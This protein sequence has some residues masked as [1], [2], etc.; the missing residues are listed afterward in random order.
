MSRQR[1]SN[2]RAATGGAVTEV[3][4]QVFKLNGR[5]L[6]AGDQLTSDIG[7]T[8]ARWQVLGAVALAGTPQPVANLAR[9]MG[10]TR[11]AV[12]RTVNDLASRGLVT[13]DVNPHHRRA[14]LVVLTEEGR[15][16]YR[17]AARRQV[18]W[19]SGLAKGLRAADLALALEVL[20]ALTGALERYEHRARRAR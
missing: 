13:F 8:S 10:L 7:L 6:A 2:R 17:A 4:L 20:K 1:G 5:L 19:A 14:Q 18:P 11:Q 3:I 16:A 12:Q 15:A 9:A